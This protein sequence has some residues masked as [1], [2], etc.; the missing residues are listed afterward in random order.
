MRYGVVFSAIMLLFGIPKE[1]GKAPELL[2]EHRFKTFYNIAESP[3]MEMTKE[4]AWNHAVPEVQE[5]QIVS[6]FDSTL[7]PSLFYASGS[8]HTK[9]LLLVLHSWSADYKQHFSIPYGIWATKNDWVFAHPDYRGAFT[10]PE[11]TASE[12]AVQDILDV[13]AYAKKHARVDTTRI[14]IAGFSGG[15]MVALI[16]AGRFPGIW[17][18]AV[19]WVP[20]YDLVQWYQVTRGAQHD[21]SGHIESSCGG[22][23]LEGSKAYEDCKKRSVS[24]YLSNARGAEVKI[25]IASGIEDSFVPPGQAI[26]AYNDLARKRDRVSEKDIRFINENHY[27]PNYLADS[28]SDSLFEDAD[29]PIVFQRTSL[30]ATLTIFNGR[31]DVIYNAGLLWLSRQRKNK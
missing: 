4:E 9:P 13:L 19:A 6:T 21:Y 15:A 28:L 8:P 11:A 24:S 23:P 26:Q 10:N 29:S 5:V 20:V 30:N 12:Q 2:Q 3:V 22:V 27:L 17:A 31:H 7:Q 16:M 18:G 25:F 1:P 14:Y